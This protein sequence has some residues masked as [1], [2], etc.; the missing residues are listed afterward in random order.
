MDSG[1]VPLYTSCVPLAPMIAGS[2][3]AGKELDTAADGEP[4]DRTPG[5]AG[6]SARATIRKRQ[7]VVVGQCHKPSV[8]E[9][10]RKRLA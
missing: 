5:Q 4:T 10:I 9:N 7:K 1:A 3:L 8:F 2:A 6:V